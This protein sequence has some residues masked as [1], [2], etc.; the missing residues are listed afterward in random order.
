M[1]MEALSPHPVNIPV[2]A[3]SK[4]EKAVLKPA[5]PAKPMKERDHAAAPPTLVVEPD[6]LDGER[7]ERYATGGFLGKGGFAICY[8]GEL[9][10]RT[11]RRSGHRFAL[12]IVKT[13]MAQRKME[14]KFRTELQIHSKMHHPNIVEF[15]RAFTF[16]SSTYIVL[17][18]CSNGS[19]MDMVRRR[20]YLT[21]PEIRR[22]TIQL[23]GAIKYMHHRNIIHRDLKMGNLFLD[24]HMNIKVGDFGLAAILMTDKESHS[25]QR[26]MTLC[27]TPNYIA[28]EI[29]EKGRK[30]HDHR[31]DFWSVGVII[32][33][34]F[35]GSPPFQSQTQ[36]EI[37]RKVAKRE[38]DWPHL[39]KCPNDIPNDAR[40]L[41]SSLLVDA[42]SRPD[43]DE[44]VS[45]PFFTRGYIPDR[46][47]PCCRKLQPKWPDN[48]PPADA[49]TR[50]K[51]YRKW[52]Q[53]CQ[54]CGVGM[55]DESQRFPPVGRGLGRTVFK[56]CQKEE[57]AGRTPI[58]P[59]PDDEVYLPFPTPSNW[60]SAQPIEETQHSFQTTYENTLPS[61]PPE[62]RA[63]PPEMMSCAA[64][65][66]AMSLKETVQE[67]TPILSVAARRPDKRSHAAKLRQDAQVAASPRSTAHRVQST[68][69]ILS[70]G[71]IRAVKATAENIKV[72][73]EWIEDAVAPSTNS[74]TDAKKETLR[75]GAVR[76]AGTS[77]Q[78]NS[79]SSGTALEQPQPSQSSEPLPT[80]VTRARTG[81]RAV[82][83]IR[84]ESAYQSST[85]AASQSR[86][87]GTTS[88][89]SSS[90]TSSRQGLIGPDDSQEVLSNT[91]PNRV[92]AQLAKFHHN[93]S[94]ALASQNVETRTAARKPASMKE[95]SIV[96]KWVDYTNKF[97]IGYV[98]NDGSIGCL[99]NARDGMPPGC[100]LVRD[101]EKHM[102]R[103]A[104]P[105]YPEKEE[106]VPQ[107]GD[108]IEFLENRG[109]EGFVRS[110][111]DAGM[112]KVT[113]DGEGTGRLYPG[114]DTYENRKKETV[115]IW[116]KFAHY[117]HSTLREDEDAASEGEGPASATGSQSKPCVKFFQRLGNV[118]VW[119]F[120]NG[121][122]QFN[123]PDHTKIVM[124]E[125]GKW[126][127]FYH[128]QPI[129]ARA[130]QHND[131]EYLSNAMLDEREILSYS[132]RDM[133]RGSH[134]RHQFGDVIKANQFE[135][136]L[137]FIEN[138]VLQWLAN[139]GLGRQDLTQ[140]IKWEG[141]QEKTASGKRGKLVWVTVGARGE[142]V[143]V[144]E[145]T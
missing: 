6:A 9:L 141:M 124:S 87:A 30:G 54:A 53:L 18:L 69:G 122:F 34:M 108:P 33:A 84:V 110:R 94:E 17:E 45:H 145:E 26:R 104:S 36:E 29:L 76:R 37:Y 132:V 42:D 113:Y 60:P 7:G 134:G 143:R 75:A 83:S 52:A 15:H 106:I 13:Q 63:F 142:D 38:Y 50:A 96:V 39:S 11:S 118:G 89:S 21:P 81:L 130:L 107:S 120:V 98:L 14:E 41:V 85:T 48:R 105:S 129:A 92:L 112:F 22:Y 117:M 86:R 61:L 100:I 82:E 144:T 115:M 16:Q 78:L 80:R 47:D 25:Y 91:L 55:I 57:A 71:P 131:V 28:P 1:A 68:Q 23:C 20:K 136:K 127:D 46:I 73:G 90:R 74:K 58:V 121:T 27:G 19:V 103:K 66:K 43:A 140:K 62:K 93:V 138:V 31:V 101:G 12:K 137:Y 64:A 59:F 3:P 40:N 32:Y 56:E 126:C 125:D 8:E 65:I 24:E 102:K 119:G 67:T 95:G 72:R 111:V 49:A 139:K 135:R 99:M 5:Q 35:C 88:R 128:L 97:G 133:L 109:E 44:I 114:V 10:D 70:D 4:G 77:K 116:K 2:R 51:Y 79:K 123:F